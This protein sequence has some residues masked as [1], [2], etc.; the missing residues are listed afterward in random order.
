MTAGAWGLLAVAFAATYSWRALGVVV[1]RRI[2]TSMW[3]FEWFGC[4]TYAL[5]GGLMFK[6]IFFASPGLAIAPLTDR[7]IAFAVGIVV[8][9]IT[10]RSVTAGFSTGALMFAALALLRQGGV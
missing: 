9:C 6:A 5:V 8:F 2:D 10:K 1:A 3:I 7:G 4:V